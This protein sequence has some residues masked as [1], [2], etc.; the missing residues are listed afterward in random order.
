MQ[1]PSLMTK[2]VTL[3]TVDPPSTTTLAPVTTVPL[4][5]SVL[6]VVVV[7]VSV[8]RVWARAGPG[9]GVPVRVELLFLVPDR[10]PGGRR[11]GRLPEQE[12]VAAVA[13]LFPAAGVRQ[14]GR[15]EG[16]LDLHRQHRAGG[17]LRLQAVDQP[18]EVV[19]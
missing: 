6:L 14:R 9:G 13:A 8:V 19:G 1:P 3:P 10:W 11:A 17:Q 12:H 4:M 5:T 7:R 16:V 15:V 2:S 18:A